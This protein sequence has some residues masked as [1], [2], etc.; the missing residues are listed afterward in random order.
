MKEEIAEQFNTTIEIVELALAIE[1][2]IKDDSNLNTTT[3][4]EI[5]SRLK[6]KG[7]SKDIGYAIWLLTKRNDKVVKK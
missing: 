3:N 7:T 1:S 6:Y 5:K 2:L 4:S